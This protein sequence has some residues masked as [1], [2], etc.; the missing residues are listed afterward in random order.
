MWNSNI[1]LEGEFIEGWIN[2]SGG[3]QGPT[4]GASQVFHSIYGQNSHKTLLFFILPLL[5]SDFAMNL[6]DNVL[7]HLLSLVLFLYCEYTVLC[8]QFIL[9]EHLYT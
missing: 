4:V 6:V 1:S 3:L 9:L 2:D 7:Y 8:D 5:L